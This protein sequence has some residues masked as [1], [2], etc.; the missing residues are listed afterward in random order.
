MEGNECLGMPSHN[1][2]LDE[3]ILNAV[4][5]LVALEGDKEVVREGRRG[6]VLNANR[7]FEHRAKALDLENCNTVM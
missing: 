2:H 7:E 4:E 6:G 3:L 1:T 5:S